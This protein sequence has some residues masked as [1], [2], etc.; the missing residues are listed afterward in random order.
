M[1]LGIGKMVRTLF[2]GVGIEVA[3]NETVVV[4]NFTYFE[5]LQALLRTPKFR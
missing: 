5:R 3:D 2:N 1:Q 4:R